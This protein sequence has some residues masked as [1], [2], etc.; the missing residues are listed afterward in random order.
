M[1]ALFIWQFADA[2]LYVVTGNNAMT[3]MRYSSILPT[4][5]K[6]VLFNLKSVFC[7]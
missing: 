4:C 7:V 2:Q 6:S 5:P 3:R 1:A